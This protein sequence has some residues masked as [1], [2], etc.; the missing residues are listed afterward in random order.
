MIPW[1]ILGPFTSNARSAYSDAV[2]VDIRGE[3][4]KLEEMLRFSDGARKV[5]VIVEGDKVKIGYGGT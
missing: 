5:P 2:Y 4:G 1:P 3:K